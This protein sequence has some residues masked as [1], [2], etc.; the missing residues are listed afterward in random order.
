MPQNLRKSFVVY[1][2]N[3][4]MTNPSIKRYNN[5]K[6]VDK[7]YFCDIW[8]IFKVGKKGNADEKETIGTHD[9]RVNDGFTVRLWQ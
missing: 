3:K 6:L 4:V 2:F 7:M 8:K 9:D 1:F 5:V